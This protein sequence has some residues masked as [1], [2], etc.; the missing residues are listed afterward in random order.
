MDKKQ[1]IAEIKRTAAENG[2]AALGV[3]KFEKLTGIKRHTW[4]GVHWR[5]WGE[6]LREAGFSEKKFGADAYD[7]AFLVEKLAEL[8]RT[9][10]RFPAKVDIIIARKSDPSFPVHQTISDKLGS[11]AERIELVRKF[12]DEHD[13]YK[14]I[15]E[16]LPETNEEEAD[17][18]STSANAKTKEGFVYLGMLKIDT[19]KRYKIGKTNLVERRNAELS[20]QLPEKLVLVHYIKTDDMSGIEAYWHRRFADKNTNGEWFDLSNEDVRAFR[21]RK[22]M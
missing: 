16:L 6:A 11:R 17:N 19:K 12:A 22:S 9:L 8:T 20:L 10:G 3:E 18:N 14:S 2:G 5:G 13:N 1:I 7:Q 4:Y 15:L 21:S